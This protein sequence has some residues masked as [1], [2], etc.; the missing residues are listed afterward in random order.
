MNWDQWNAVDD[1]ICGTLIGEDMDLDAAL[2]RN[3][4]G[5][6]PAIDVSAAQGQLLSL[7]VKI[8]GAKRVLEVGTLGGY[9]TIILARAVSAAGKV[10]TLELEP[11]HAEVAAVN[12]AEAGLADRV[13]IHVGPALDLLDSLATQ[14][15]EPFDFTFIDA[16]KANSPYYFE[17]AAA[18]SRPGAVIIVDNVVRDGSLIDPEMTEDPSTAGNL[19]LHE[20]LGAAPNI[21][22][23]TIQ[24][25]GAKGYDGF[26][27]AVVDS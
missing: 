12:I 17:K 14:N 13:D 25:V 26:T 6:L 5:G 11:R 16:D 19:L 24:T 15:P 21:D 23:T 22:A 4:E 2:V 20:M 18:M 1:Y 3:L 10:V 7:L 27:I 8:S 9:S